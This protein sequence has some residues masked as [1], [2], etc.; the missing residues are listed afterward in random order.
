[1]A[2]TTTILGFSLKNITYYSSTSDYTRAGIIS[3]DE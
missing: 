3:I 2:W 1:M